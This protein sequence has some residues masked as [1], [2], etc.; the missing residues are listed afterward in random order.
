MEHARSAELLDEVGREP[1]LAFDAVP[2]GADGGGERSRL[3]PQVPGG[4]GGCFCSG[5]GRDSDGVQLD[6]EL[7]MQ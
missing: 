6:H 4:T 2:G 7:A 1:P 3:V 5:H